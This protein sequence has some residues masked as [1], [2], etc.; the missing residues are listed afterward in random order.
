MSVEESERIKY[1]IYIFQR[2]IIYL[3]VRISKKLTSRKFCRNNFDIFPL[4]FPIG[5]LEIGHVWMNGDICRPASVLEGHSGH[6][7][8]YPKDLR[9]TRKQNVRRVII[10]HTSQ[11]RR[12]LKRCKKKRKK[13]KKP[14]I[15]KNEKK[16]FRTEQNAQNEL[17][18]LF[19]QKSKDLSNRKSS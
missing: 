19:S 4:T 1:V 3:S 11:V 5:N 15:P 2:G 13:T 10:A 9:A 14:R 16:K 18:L 12:S 17:Y 8:L 7:T 6:F